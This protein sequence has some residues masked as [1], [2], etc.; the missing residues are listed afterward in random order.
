MKNI[1]NEPWDIH[2]SNVSAIEFFPGIQ[3]RV[4][5][6]DENDRTVL[7]LE[8][9]PGAIWPEPDIHFPGPEEVFVLEGIFND[10]KKDYPPGSFIH[11]PL[12]SQ[13]TPQSKTGCKL[14]VFFPEG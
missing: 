12:N 10:G 4:L 1:K 3:K 11:S 14:L 13:H 8:I 5:Y 6:S 9:S 2:I 7:V